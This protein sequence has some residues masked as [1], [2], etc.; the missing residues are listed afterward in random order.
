MRLV[1]PRCAAQYEVGEHAIP[2]GGREV[3]CSACGHGWFQQNEVSLPQQTLVADQMPP[4]AM[5]GPD[6]VPA[7]SP[8]KPLDEKVMAIL[9]EEALREAAA[10]RAERARAPAPPPPQAPPAESAGRAPET[11]LV[12]PVLAVVFQPEAPAPAARRGL[13]PDIEEINSTLAAESRRATAPPPPEG[14]SGFRAGFGLMMAL[15]AM[16]AGAY[17]LA[18]RISAAVPETEGA[19]TAYVSHV[20]D[21]RRQLDAAITILR[22]RA[23]ALLPAAQ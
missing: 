2:K 15:A 11:T 5:P 12:Q 14:R 10:R 7:L 17:A 22:D 8:R 18:P 20:D 6:P 16:A 4:T 13:L 9:R 23:G 3:Q 21:L 1:C 19:M